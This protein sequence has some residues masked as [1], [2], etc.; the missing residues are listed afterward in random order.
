MSDLCFGIIEDRSSDSYRTFRY[1]V[2]IQGIHSPALSDLATVDLPWAIP[3]V[4]NS[5][6]M[7]G[8]GWSANGYLQ[9]T[10][11]AILFA[12]EDFQIPIIIGAISGVQGNGNPDYNA[13]ASTLSLMPPATPPS[14]NVKLKDGT[15]VTLESLNGILP[16]GATM[17]ES[18]YIGSLTPP[19]VT[20]LK[21]VI[22]SKE[23]G[24][25]GYS[26][27]NS[28]GFLGKYQF[29]AMFLEDMGYI[30]KGSYSRI[31]NNLTVIS[32]PSNWSGVDGMTSKDAFLGSISIQES[33]MDTMLKRNYSK[34]MS[35]DCVS[36]QSPPEKTAGVLM[37]AHLKGAGLSGCTGY[38]KLGKNSSDAYG[39][40][41]ESYYRIGYSAIC[42]KNTTEV[43]TQDNMNVPAIDR[44]F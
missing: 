29:G 13:V 35:N 12:D 1:K 17:V 43:P 24:S 36:A 37:A 4:S 14:P 19:Q 20:T 25:S 31:R 10:T 11:V 44:N 26:C 30:I 9:G 40:S 22:A 15:I 6:A 34:L 33:C 27:V 8:I 7:S 23:S 38:V 32:S 18:P 28:L 5:A 41:C 3:S 42:G 21:N 2:R 39:T 16:D